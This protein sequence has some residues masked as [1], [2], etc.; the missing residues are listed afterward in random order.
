MKKQTNFNKYKK[1]ASYYDILTLVYFLPHILLIKDKRK[2]SYAVEI[3]VK[4]QDC[5]NLF[6]YLAYD[7]MMDIINKF[8][9]NIIPNPH[10]KKF[11]LVK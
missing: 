4:A 1:I 7:N 8:G 5:Y 2:P 11:N 6:E 9:Y 3:P 10:V